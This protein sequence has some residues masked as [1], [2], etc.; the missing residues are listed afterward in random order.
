MT[1]PELVIREARDDDGGAL[2]ALLSREWAA[3]DGAAF[4]AT[5]DLLAAPASHFTQRGGRLWVVAGPDELLGA[6]G[7]VPAARSR[8]FE[9]S[10]ICLSQAIRGQ[11]LAA[12]LVI[13]AEAFA[14]ASGA[15]R[16]NVWTDERL[17]DGI[18]FLERQGFL[19]DP[20][21]RR[22]DDGSEALDAHFSRE[23][24][25]EISSPL[26]EDRPAAGA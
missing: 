4:A 7:V 5:D 9:I 13:G 16:L 17:V 18:A 14:A 1:T 24:A 2:Q 15:N 3:Y 8:E 26:S 22:R 6:L 23:I 19:R 10:L 25:P 20:G 21:V 12:A 11:G